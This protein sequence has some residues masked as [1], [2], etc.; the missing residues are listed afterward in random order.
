MQHLQT[1]PAKWVQMDAGV[2][3]KPALM[4]HV[5]IAYATDLDGSPLYDVIAYDD[6]GRRSVEHSPDQ[7]YRD[8]GAA[9]T[10]GDHL[11]SLRIGDVVA[12]PCFN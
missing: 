5:E 3:V 12:A 2:W 11:T 1:R 7:T 9:R 8:F 10:I 4:G 6:R